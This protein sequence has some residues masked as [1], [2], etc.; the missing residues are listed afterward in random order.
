MSTLTKPLVRPL[1]QS[2]P[3]ESGSVPTPPIAHLHQPLVRPLPG[4]YCTGLRHGAGA[5][6][7]P[8]R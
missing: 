5:G 4:G 1:V 6:H 7:V 8:V 2:P 3:R